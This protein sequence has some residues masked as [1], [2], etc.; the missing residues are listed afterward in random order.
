MPIEGEGKGE[1][2]KRKPPTPEE[3][4][5][6]QEAFEKG[7]KSKQRNHDYATEM[8]GQCVAGDPGNHVYVVAFIENLHK[9][10]NNNKKGATYSGS[11]EWATG[12]S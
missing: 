6:L 3:R 10:Y 2:P 7:E 9:K 11:R 8:F 4:R 12:P 5:R 1:R